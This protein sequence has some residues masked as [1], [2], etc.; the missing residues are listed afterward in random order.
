MVSDEQGYY[1]SDTK[2]N[3]QF[4]TVYIEDGS[5]LDLES[6]NDDGGADMTQDADEEEEVM[7]TLGFQCTVAGVLGV[8]F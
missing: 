4:R 5:D 1:S 7:P 8:T 2:G 3:P 6:T